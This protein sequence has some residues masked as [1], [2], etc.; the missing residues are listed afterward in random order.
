MR[1][2]QQASGWLW[3]PGVILAILLVSLHP[4]ASARSQPLPLPADVQLKVDKAIDA[5]VA[6]LKGGMWPTDKNHVLG[7]VALPALTLLECGV[8][9][10]NPGVQNAAAFVRGWCL[11]IDTTYEI[12]LSIL[13][14]DKL[15]EAKDRDLIQKLALRLI[16][17]QGPTG[18][19]TY[20]CPSYDKDA[21]R[22]YKQ[23][24]STLKKLDMPVLFDPL[25]QASPGEVDR[26]KETR[27]Q[28]DKERGRTG[29]SGNAISTPY[30]PGSRNWAWCIK[31]DSG[32]DDAASRGNAKA[33][34]V[35]IPRNLQALPVLHLPASLSLVDPKDKIN[36]P[37]WGTTDNSNTQFAIL[38]LWAARR[39][40]V[41]TARTLNLIAMRFY[42]SQNGDGSWG[43]HYRFGG[44]EAERP[45]MTCVGLLGLAVYH[46]LAR[47]MDVKAMK[48]QDSRIVKG[49]LA[50]TKNVGM[51]TGRTEG[52]PMANLYFLW[53]VE[54]VGV[55]YDLPTIGNKEWYRWG[56]EI[57]VANQTRNGNWEN[58]G[59]HGA[60]PTIDTCLALL[61]LK[62][63]N[64]AQDLTR[65]LPFKPAA[66]SEEVAKK[67]PREPTAKEVAPQIAAAKVESATSDPLRSVAKEEKP[68]TATAPA[69]RPGPFSTEPIEEK[70]SKAWIWLV[71]LLTLLIGSGV[72][73][74][75][76]ARKSEAEEDEEEEIRRRP[77]GRVKR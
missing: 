44:G 56:A 39:H 65:A 37:I 72:V 42:T 77:R 63:A 60:N 73:L 57:L 68:S 27:R 1:P 62:R 38:A 31:M 20:K 46:G 67:L 35:V 12:A 76:I 52:L 4:W 54:R 59:Y 5:G 34:V 45:P 48:G 28:G 14:L 25:A 7:Y 11:K 23:L 75:L 41:P 74:A 21:D 47:D 13:F 50:L 6:Y 15:G 24:L 71:G 58:G 55:L 18:G 30:S 29:E 3:K 33:K 69:A 22:Y 61:F 8:P 10:N 40:Q 32:G 26:D 43:Y 51:P 19:W 64:L 9:A 16:A 49:L 17:G 66:L 53:S 36:E 2:Y 70:T